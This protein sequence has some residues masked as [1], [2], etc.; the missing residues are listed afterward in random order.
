MACRPERSPARH[1]SRQLSADHRPDQE[2]SRARRGC[3]GCSVWSWP[4]GRRSEPGRRRSATRPARPQESVEDGVVD[5]RVEAGWSGKK[6]SICGSRSR[7][8]SAQ[9]K[10]EVIE[11]GEGRAAC[12]AGAASP[13]RSRSPRSAAPAGAGGRAGR[14]AA[15]RGGG[16]PRAP[17][18]PARRRSPNRVAPALQ[19]VRGA[20]EAALAASPWTGRRSRPRRRGAL[21]RRRHQRGRHA[22]QRA[23]GG[24]DRHR[25]QHRRRRLV[26]LPR[27]RRARRAEEDDPDHL[28][29]T[30]HREGAGR[31]QHR[32][33]ERHPGPRSR[34]GRPTAPPAPAPRAPDRGRPAAR[35]RNR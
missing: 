15:R 31:R 35:S 32:R 5:V 12:T 25:H 24:Q 2:R 7:G 3:R 4:C 14:P 27:R 29:E 23:G 10:C 6:R 13:R 20:A 19:G 26:R 21:E 34:G 30:G 22:E 33:R 18:A 1:S 8:R 16:A 17:R 9:A 28:D 11:L